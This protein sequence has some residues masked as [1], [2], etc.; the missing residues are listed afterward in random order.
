MLNGIS[1]GLTKSTSDIIDLQ[2]FAGKES[3]CLQSPS[4]QKPQNER[5]PRED[6]R[7]PHYDVAFINYVAR[8]DWLVINPL[9]STPFV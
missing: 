5:L 2:A 3:P 7:A 9:C 4:K 8:S 6:T 1:L